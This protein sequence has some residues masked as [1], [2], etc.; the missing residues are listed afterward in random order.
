MK[1]KISIIVCTF[2]SEKYLNDCL[3]SLFI[4]NNSN[5]EIVVIDDK[6]EDKTLKI[7]KNGK[8]IHAFSINSFKKK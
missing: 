7:L 6:S 3:R 4:K 2:N 1:I 5:Y 8:K